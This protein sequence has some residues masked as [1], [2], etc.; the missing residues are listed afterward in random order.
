MT[1]SRRPPRAHHRGPT[2]LPHRSDVA[3][4]CWDRV[5]ADARDGGPAARVIGL[6]PRRRG[7]RAGEETGSVLVEV[8]VGHEMVAARAPEIH[9]A[10]D[11]ALRAGPRVVRLRLDAVQRF[12]ASGLGL[13]LRVH[14]QARQ[15]GVALACTCAPWQMIA[16]LRRTRL[17][18]VLDVGP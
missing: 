7:D 16:V 1:R 9:D 11:R 5:A 6:D 3:V 2:V 4:T 13:L 17:D 12:D 8:V 18:R 14:Q 10:V 15:Q